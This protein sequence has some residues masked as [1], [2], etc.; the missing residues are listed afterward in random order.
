MKAKLLLLLRMGLQMGL[1]GLI[2][3]IGAP[4]GF[5]ETSFDVVLKKKFW[6][7]GRGVL[8][9]SD[10]AIEFRAKDD[11]RSRR[12]SYEDIQYFD[13]VS[14]QEII[15]LTYE[16]SGWKLGR[17][18]QFRFVLSEGEFTDALF[19]QVSRGI[20]RPVTNRV[21]EVREAVE[22]ELPVKHLHA[23]GGCEGT[24]LFTKNEVYYRTSHARDAR[25][26]QLRRDVDSVWSH[27]RYH[28]ELHVYDNNRREFSRAKVYKF[29]LKRPL[30][31]EWY[32]GLKLRL[33]ELN[34]RERSPIGR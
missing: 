3:M 27:D 10:D 32:R 2:G 15:V 11:E 26:W 24:L 20:G 13:R 5:A 12:W 9:V 28:L 30:D 8:V 1:M 19:D 29:D 25:Q 6:P 18:R 22:M 14:T 21:F 31:P 4:V 23:L 7:D 17:D 34:A 33:Y 16:D